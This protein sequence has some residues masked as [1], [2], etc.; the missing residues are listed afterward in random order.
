MEMVH[1]LEQL[2]D[3]ATAASSGSAT[4]LLAGRLEFVATGWLSV[5]ALQLDNARTAAV[6]AVKYP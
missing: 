2:L 6:I 3:P 4:E 5:P 1:P